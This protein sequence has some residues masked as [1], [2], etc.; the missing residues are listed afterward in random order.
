MQNFDD[1]NNL[2]TKYARH[3]K[4]INDLPQLIHNDII[5]YP[6]LKKSD[7]IPQLRQVYPSNLTRSLILQH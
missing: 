4:K 7:Y 1:L 2:A 5:V 6:E 3:K